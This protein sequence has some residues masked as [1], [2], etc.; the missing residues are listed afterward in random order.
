MRRMRMLARSRTWMA[1][2][3]AV[4]S[5]ALAALLG[6][7][8]AAGL[9]PPA[10]G[11]AMWAT[12]HRDPARSGDDPEAGNPVIPS[13]AWQSPEL[14]APIYGQPLVLGSRVYVATV[15]DRLYA[16]DASSGKVI[17]EQSAGVPVPSGELPCG[18]ITPT[19]GIVGT[20]V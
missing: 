10:H 16:L 3:A 1:T 9:S 14:G 13:L 5:F 19:V 2:P 8:L 6:C 15:G 20:P 18:D 12:Y 17:W 4:A 7:A 11:E